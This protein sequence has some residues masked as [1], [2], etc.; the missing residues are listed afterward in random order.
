MVWFSMLYICL[1]KHAFDAFHLVY[2]RTYK[3]IGT[4]F[5][6]ENGGFPQYPAVLNSRWTILIETRLF[7]CWYNSAVTLAAV[8]RYFFPA[9][10]L[11][12]RRS[13][14]VSLKVCSKLLQLLEVF[15]C[16][17]N[18]VMVLHMVA[19]EK[20]SSSAVL[21]KQFTLLQTQLG[22]AFNLNFSKIWRKNYK[23]TVK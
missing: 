2:C 18:S 15:P 9:M 10:R 14:S 13:L 3:I 23:Y 19:I 5:K 6:L 11:N 20:L 22:N 21:V 7:R 4:L 17:L 12:A 8:V 1:R 16:Y